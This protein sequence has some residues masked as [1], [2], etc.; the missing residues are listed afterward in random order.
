M[1]GGVA[2]DGVEEEGNGSA[3]AFAGG[4]GQVFDGSLE[5]GKVA[6]EGRGEGVGCGGGLGG[7]ERLEPVGIEALGIEP[8]AEGVGVARLGATADGW[9]RFLVATNRE[10]MGNESGMEQKSS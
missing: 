5:D 1:R 7:Q 10:R 2:A 3:L 9:I 8:M 6:G 4:L